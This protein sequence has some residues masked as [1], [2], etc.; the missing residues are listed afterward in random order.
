MHGV[1]DRFEGNQA[2]I[3]VEKEKAEFTVENEKLPENSTV[4][5]WFHVTHD[6]ESYAI[7]AVD[8]AKTEEQSTANALLME[9]LRQ[10]KKTSKL[11]RED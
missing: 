3:L 4:G 6:Q 5:T 2:V 1:L 7:V 9:K 11:K 8:I 10:K